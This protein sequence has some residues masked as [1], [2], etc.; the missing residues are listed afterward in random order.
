MSFNTKRNTTFKNLILLLIFF[1]TA[2]VMIVAVHIYFQNLINKL[3]NC[4]KNYNNRIY[5]ANMIVSEDINKIESLFFQL[6]A[7]TNN[8]A[9]R[10]IIYKNI[11]KLIK[12]IKDTLDIL[13]KGGIYK[14]VIRLNISGHYIYTK[15]IKIAKDKD[16]KIFLIKID[17]IPKLAELNKMTLSIINKLKEI[18]KNKNILQVYRELRLINKRAP[19]FF[20]RLIENIQRII[21]EENLHLNTLNKDIKSKQKFYE[22]IELGLIILTIF[23]SL[24]LG[25]II[26]KQILEGNRKLQQRVMEE[27]KKSREK[28]K[29]MLQQSRLAQMGEMLSMIAHQWRQP[30]SAISATSSTIELKCKLNKIDKE[31]IVK[32]AGKISS[33]SQHLSSTIDDFRDFFKANK[34][35]NKTSCVEIINNVLNIVQISLDNKNITLK[36][37]FQ[38]QS[39]FVTYSNELKQVILN[40]IKNAEDVLIEKKIKDPYISLKSYRE[41]GYITIEVGDNAGGIPEDIIDKI[42]DPYFSTKL[43]KDGTGLGLYMSKIIIEEHCNG[44][45]SVYNSE[46]G[47]VFKIALPPS[48]I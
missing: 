19:I 37:D 48:D 6:S 41:N 21:Y 13:E 45:L 8:E 23:I 43:K 24:F 18:E 29:Q 17:I 9:G 2:L 46:D 15:D 1:I 5:V 10:K 28:D 32:L 14:R 3:E 33:Y 22:N 26:S 36:K 4:T 47:A 25:I 44:K 39:K 38:C 7:S 27:V 12:H 16:S 20:N 30:L 34:T 42:F 11:Q 31:Q 35:K 40:L